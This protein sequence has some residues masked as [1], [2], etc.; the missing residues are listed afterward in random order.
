MSLDSIQREEMPVDILIIGGGA[1]GLSCAIQIKKSI[2]KHNEAVASGSATGTPIE[3]PMIVVLE[4]GTEVG[5]HSLSGAVMNPVAI[6]ELIPD[7]LEKGFPVNCDVKTESFYYLTEKGSL[8]S[9]IIPPP[10]HNKGNHI[11]SLSEMNRWMAQQAEAMGIN[12]FAGFTAVEVLIEEGKVVGARTGDR[13]VNK[14]GEPKENFEPGMLIKAKV[15][16]FADGTRSPLLKTVAE[17]LGLRDGRNPEVFE[18]GVKEIIQLPKGSLPAGHV[19]HTLGFPLSKTIGGTFIYSLK[20][21]QIVVGICLYLD[22][23]DPMLDAHRELQKLKT[24]PLLQKMLKG[25][26]VIAYGGKTLPAGGWYSMS[27]LYTHGMMACG[28]TVSMVDV[29]KLKG[30]HLAMKAGM[31]AGETAVEALIANDFSESFLKKYND[32]VEASYIKS[33]LWKTRNFHQALSK[34]I[35]ASAPSLM[36]QELTGGWTFGDPKKI[37]HKDFEE[38]KTIAETWGKPDVPENKLPEAD[39]KLFFDKLSSVYLTGT[40]HD[41]DSPCHLLVDNTNICADTCYPKYN[42]PC[43]HFCPANVY[44]M[45]DDGPKK[46]L[47]VNYTNCIHCQSCDIKCPFDNIDWTLPE[48]GGGPQYKNV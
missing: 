42:S 13:G 39:G 3:E 36:L 41:E 44:E 18:L 4:K 6:Q 19:T 27:K 24:H 26:Q 30:I 38:T 25:G 15:T 37:K 29:K 47:Q 17:K 16:I 43:N 40:M 9:P 32:R 46:R 5:A 7:Y 21:D 35:F 1:A 20:D 10:F 2:D 33:E 11:V 22:S 28:D 31:L 34:G 23:V 45:I 14:N 8:K 48:A 12:I